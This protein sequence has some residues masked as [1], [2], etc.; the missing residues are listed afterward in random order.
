MASALTSPYQDDSIREVV[1]KVAKLAGKLAQSSVI[2][3]RRR[4]RIVPQSG[5]SYTLGSG[6]TGTVKD[7][8]AL[9]RSA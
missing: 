1:P 4:V 9:W 3:D 7:R 6:G 5:Q 2:T 8:Q